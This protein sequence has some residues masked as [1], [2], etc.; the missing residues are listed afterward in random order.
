MEFWARCRPRGVM[1]SAKR[2]KQL[3]ENFREFVDEI[4]EG[5]SDLYGAGAARGYRANASR[6]LGESLA[7]PEVDALA[8]LSGGRAMGI[9]LAASQ[10]AVGRITLVHV[11]EGHAGGPV[12]RALLTEAVRTLRAGGVTGIV[13][14]YVP[15]CAL[16]DEEVF[17]ALGFERFERAL[18]MA[19][20]SSGPLCGT[21]AAD[22]E[23]YGEAA[24]PAVADVIQDAYRDDPGRNLH[25]GVRCHDAALRFLRRASEGAFGATRPEYGRTATRDGVVAGAIVGSQVA[26]EVGFVIQVAVRRASRG[27]GLGTGLLLDLAEAFRQAGLS[28]MALGVTV[29]NPAARLYE[30]LAFRKVRRVNS[31][32]WWRP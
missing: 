25:V 20:L 32:A 24:W 11:L 31:F 6:L 3:P 18:M 10:D 2:I 15:L 9:L 17:T 23:P 26:P 16:R 12:E 8:V 29:G 5:V 27:E 22:S 19:D 21:G 13:S 28:R 30:G 4:A 1:P 14:D 7:N